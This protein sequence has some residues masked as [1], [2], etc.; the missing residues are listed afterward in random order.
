[1]EGI[2]TSMH[3]IFVGSCVF[4]LLGI[5]ICSVCDI[6]IDFLYMYIFFFFFAFC[7]I[8]VFHNRIASVLLIWVFCLFLGMV[9]YRFA[10]PV[11]S[12][13][14]HVTQYRE[15]TRQV[16]GYITAEPDVRTDGVRYVVHVDTVEEIPVHGN[17]YVSYALHPQF[18]YGDNVELFCTIRE[19]EPI[20]T[21]RYDM[22]LARS[23]VFALCQ[24]PYMTRNGDG[25]GIFLFR[26][27]FIVKAHIAKKISLLW[28]EPYASFMAG[29]LY[30]YRGGLGQLNELFARTGVTHII[31]IS[32][33]N[34]TIIATIL[35]GVCTGLAIPR[36][37]AFWFVVAGIAVF[38]LFAGAS[39]SVVRAGIMGGLV[40]FARQVGR[41]STVGIVMI[42]TAV[43]M[44]LHNP[45]ILF[46][47]AGFQLSF[48]STLGLV[49]LVPFIQK[50][51]ENVR[52]VLGV[53]E[54]LISTLA[55]IIATLPLIVYQFGR[56]SLVAPIVNVLILWVLPWIMLLGAIAVVASY[57]FF[58]F[59]SIVAWVAYVGMRYIVLVVSWFAALLFSSIEISLPWWGMCLCYIGGVF[60]LIKK[61]NILLS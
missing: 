2:Y 13:V 42:Y 17:I 38:V 11:S 32:G 31:A 16:T 57:I 14:S 29:L 6:R 27:I 35:V 37:R 28:H 40:L 55:A 23:H 34:I 7:V 45:L 41:K 25:E 47:D 46:W 49:Y 51:F 44:C 53:K 60:L 24:S 15:E 61:K 50:P 43:I 9:R 3:K 54:S 21:F 39:A 33:Y 8:F 10:F 1:M 59:A 30:G 5:V 56:L 48:V 4:F 22:Y 20:E 19:P 58:P 26:W 12:S 36:K 52:E 18:A